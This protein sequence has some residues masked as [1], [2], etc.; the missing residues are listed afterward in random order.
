MTPLE[1]TKEIAAILENKKARDITAIRI[2]EVSTLAD[3]FLLASGSS[4]TQVRAL[5]DEIELR[6]KEKF[7]LLPGRVEGYNSSS[8]ILVDYGDVVVHIFLEET[9]E[10]YSLERLWT[11]GEVLTLDE[12]MAKQGL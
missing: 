7:A 6:M 11:D 1:L 9:R 8:W 12:I 4:T 3:Y 5:S 10:F 2:G